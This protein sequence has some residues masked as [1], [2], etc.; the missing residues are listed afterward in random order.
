MTPPPP[1]ETATDPI[2]CAADM[3]GRWR[4]LM[5]PLGFGKRMLWVGFVG[6]DHR[7]IKTLIDLERSARPDPIQ[8]D[9]LM[10]ELSSVLAQEMDPGTTVALLLTGPGRGRVSTARRQWV[11]EL[12]ASAARHGVPLRPVISADDHEMIEVAPPVWMTR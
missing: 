1:I 11:A 4:A 5:G 2:T 7:M 3:L 9:G 12:T 6:P 8:I 10:A